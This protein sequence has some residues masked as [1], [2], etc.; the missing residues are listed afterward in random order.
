M[1][2]GISNR[3]MNSYESAL[4]LFFLSYIYLWYIHPLPVCCGGF[5]QTV[6]SLPLWVWQSTL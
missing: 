6:I 1:Q 5:Y 4:W 3:R 2:L